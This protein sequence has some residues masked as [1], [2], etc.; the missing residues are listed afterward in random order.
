MKLGCA[1]NTI[2]GFSELTEPCGA[3]ASWND[4]SGLSCAGVARLDEAQAAGT[5]RGAASAVSWPLGTLACS[6]AVAGAKLARQAGEGISCGEWAS[7][8]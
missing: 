8:K 6:L 2:L 5:L 4:F 1:E 7:E 3:V